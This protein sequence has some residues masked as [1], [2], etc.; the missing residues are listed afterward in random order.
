MG[1]WVLILFLDFITHIQDTYFFCKKI[2]KI[3]HITINIMWLLGNISLHYIDLVK[4]KKSTQELLAGL[5]RT[6]VI[7]LKQ[8][9]CCHTQIRLRQ[10]LCPPP[11][12]FLLL[13]SLVSSVV[14]KIIAGCCVVSPDCGHGEMGWAEAGT[15]VSPCL[16]HLVL[17]TGQR[18]LSWSVKTLSF[19]F[20]VVSVTIQTGEL[21]FKLNQCLAKMFTALNWWGWNKAVKRF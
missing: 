15:S 16:I 2:K 5:T 1:S 19:F 4:P 13:P 18:I 10:P 11:T 7:I 12:H 3:K 17:R 6:Q 9:D 8:A 21:V 20:P 14:T